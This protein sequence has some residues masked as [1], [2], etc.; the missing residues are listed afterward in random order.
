MIF[1]ATGRGRKS[2]GGKGRGQKAYATLFFMKELRGEGK[3][4]PWP[5]PASPFSSPSS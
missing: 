4:R 5:R 1:E 3:E 2:E